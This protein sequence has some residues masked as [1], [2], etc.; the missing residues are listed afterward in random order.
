M[1][2]VRL[3][4]YVLVLAAAYC[5]EHDIPVG[6]LI[7]HYLTSFCVGVSNLF[8]R[9]AMETHGQYRKAVENYG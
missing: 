2:W 6:P 1:N 5:D 9:A 8:W 7:W 4:F 3:G